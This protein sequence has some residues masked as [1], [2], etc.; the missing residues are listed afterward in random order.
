[1]TVVGCID[2]G[3]QLLPAGTR[4][5]RSEQDKHVALVRCLSS[6]QSWQVTCQHGA[7]SLD[8][9]GNCTT[10]KP[11]VEGQAYYGRLICVRTVVEL[12]PLSNASDL[13]FFIRNVIWETSYDMFTDN[14]NSARA[15]RF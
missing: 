6:Q 3:D 11:Q 4:L 7:W 8:N 1:V 2:P 10:T 12:R 13:S 9:V 5:V 14:S 15:L